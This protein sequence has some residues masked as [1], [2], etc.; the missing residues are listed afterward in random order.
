M[1]QFQS[2]PQGLVR[3]LWGKWAQGRRPKERFGWRVVQVGSESQAK[4]W[5][6]E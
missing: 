4:V 2:L 5:G 1:C 6:R 3:I